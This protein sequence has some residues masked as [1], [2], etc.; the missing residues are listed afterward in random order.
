MLASHRAL[1]SCN[2]LPNVRARSPKAR[3]WRVSPFFLLPPGVS[4]VAACACEKG[5]CLW[6]WEKERSEKDWNSGT[7]FSFFTRKCVLLPTHFLKNFKCCSQSI[8]FDPAMETRSNKVDA[9]LH[10]LA[11]DV[12]DQHNC[13]LHAA[14][15]GRFIL[16]PDVSTFPQVAAPPLLPQSAHRQPR[17]SRHTHRA[18]LAAL[19]HSFRCRLCSRRLRL[20]S[21]PP[22]RYRTCALLHGRGS[23]RH[24]LFPQ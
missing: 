13:F 2:A 16:A 24:N 11:K 15:A 9:Y 23:V 6:M 22:M 18:Y 4:R 5:Q 17:R 3:L 10:M 14:R 1:E 7:E 19:Q 20:A 8:R 21:R 12:G